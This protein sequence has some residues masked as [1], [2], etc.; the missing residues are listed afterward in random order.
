MDNIRILRVIEYSG[1]RDLVEPQVAASLHG[2]KRIVKQGRTLTIKA[3]TIG[4]V[5]EVLDDPLHRISTTD[6]E[7]EIVNLDN[8]LTTT[9]TKGEP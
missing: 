3:A 4:T 5:G 9:T 2:E 6:E 7:G 8:H 1:P